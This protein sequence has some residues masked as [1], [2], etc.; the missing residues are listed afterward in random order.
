MEPVLP[1][2]GDV[3]TKPYNDSSERTSGD[4]EMHEL[5]EEKRVPDRWMGTES[6]M[7]DMRMLG[8]VQVLRVSASWWQKGNEV[9]R[10]TEGRKTSRMRVERRDQ[11]LIMVLCSATSASSPC[12]VLVLS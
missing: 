11:W 5:G 9:D 2:Q 10:Q 3:E 7:R 6:D 1:K 4:V 12:L 8:R